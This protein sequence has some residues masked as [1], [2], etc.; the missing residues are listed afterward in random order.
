[1]AKT[2]SIG[3]ILFA[4]VFAAWQFYQ[5]GTS[6]ERVLSLPLE[7]LVGNSEPIQL[8]PSMNPL[9]L[10]LTSKYDVKL[11]RHQIEAFSHDVRLIGPGGLMVFENAGIVYP[12]LEQEA[13]TFSTQSA[14]T[15]LGTFEVAGADR[16]FLD[17]RIETKKAKI[18]EAFLTVRRNVSAVSY[19]Y[20]AIAGLAFFLGLA[21]AVFAGRR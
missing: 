6:G 8:D 16:Y 17:W 14:H 21:L 19:L 9:R 12:P 2:G 7:N 3:L 5:Y 1:M 13:A 18:G 11:E 15:V 4:I 10:T 20:A